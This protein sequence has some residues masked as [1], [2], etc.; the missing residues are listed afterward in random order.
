MTTPS[1]TLPPIGLRGP[2]LPT[3]E[4]FTALLV[5]Q[6]DKLPDGRV[7]E[8]FNTADTAGKGKIE[9]VQA[10]KVILDEARRPAKG[11]GLLGGLFGSK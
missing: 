2:Y 3:A 9:F 7:S 8:M 11:G 1:W 10:Y 6:G 5:S 4:Q